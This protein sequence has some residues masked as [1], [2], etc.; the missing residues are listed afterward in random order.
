MHA[1][2]FHDAAL[3]LQFD[4]PPRQ[5][6]QNRIDRRAL[7]L[8]LHHVV[9]LGI[10]GQAHMLLLHRAEQRIDLRQRLDFV[11]P[12]LDAIRESS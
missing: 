1:L 2:R 12:K 8:R 5:L 6:F 10:D 9:R 11:A 7:A 4:F 3:L